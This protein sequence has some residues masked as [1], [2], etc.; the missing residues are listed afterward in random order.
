MGD[1]ADADKPEEPTS[2]EAVIG[3][4]MALGGYLPPAQPRKQRQ[5]KEGRNGK[6]NSV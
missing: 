5:P 4:A 2:P 3:P 1:K 6:G